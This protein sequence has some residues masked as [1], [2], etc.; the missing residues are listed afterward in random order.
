MDLFKEA[1]FQLSTR[2]FGTVAEIMIQRL[3]G[4]DKN[5][6]QYHDLFDQDNK[7][8]IEVKFSV[9]RKSHEAPIQENAII[10]SIM[11]NFSINR[12]F[13][14]K[15][16]K[17]TKFDCNIQHIKRHQFEILYY[18]LFFSECILIFKIESKN[19]NEKIYY[20]DKQYKDKSEDGQF[21]L[22]QSTLQIHLNDYLHKILTYEDL[23]KIL[24]RNGHAPTN[25]IA[26]VPEKVDTTGHYHSSHGPI[27]G[28]GTG[29]DRNGAHHHQGEL[30]GS[31]SGDST[32]ASSGVGMGPGVR[33][34]GASYGLPSGARHG[35]ARAAFESA[36][37]QLRHLRD[38][39]G[40]R[41]LARGTLAHWAVRLFGSRRK[42]SVQGPK[43][44][45]LQSN[46]KSVAPI[47]TPDYLHRH[48]D[49]PGS[50]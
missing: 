24:K 40:K 37:Q 38:Q 10:E 5:K 31:D 44:Q 34:V 36:L 12:I 6:N 42:Q 28:T 11:N 20:S 32:Q 15:N 16:W 43:H 9:V 30:F 19:I 13:E 25:S 50:W 2:R 18:G 35:D 27:H 29:Q 1:I 23:Y 14:F 3:L 45:A 21:H 41:P 4:L 33:K 39:R 46:Q 8:R 48:A 17:L 26:C 47:Q 22:N 49:T 7:E